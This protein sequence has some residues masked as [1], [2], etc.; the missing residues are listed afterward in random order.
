MRR[1]H[2]FEIMDQSWC[3]PIVRDFMTDYL[4]Q[5]L[6]L[7]DPYRAVAPQLAE[8][9]RCAHASRVVDIGSGAGGPWLRLRQALAE[10][11]EAVP[12]LLTD[13]HPHSKAVR[14]IEAADDGLAYYAQSVEA[15]SLPEEL[16]GFRTLFSSF[17]HFP[18][19][20]A[21]AVLQDA[22]DKGQG[23]GVFELTQ[24]KIVPLLSMLLVP[25]FVLLLTPTIRPFRFSRLLLTYLLPVVPLTACFDGVVSG[26]RTYTPE[27]MRD[28]TRELP[29]REYR[30][31]SG[32]AK[33]QHGPGVITYLIGY[34]AELAITTN[35]IPTSDEKV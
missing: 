34:P 23:I 18:P 4:Q 19:E 30:W 28:M 21:R 8:A 29:G 17:H 20:A 15:A 7:A 5:V 22:V 13:L 12:I 24:R 26:L 3:P 9:I 6:N 14:K 27:E 2:L 11:G 32:E 10:Q 33:L 1:L 16:T 35:P 31:Q 25:L